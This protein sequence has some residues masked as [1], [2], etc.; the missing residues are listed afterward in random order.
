MPD[1]PRRAFIAKLK[2]RI[3]ELEAIGPGGV[4]RELRTELDLRSA[5]LR[6]LESGP[7][8]GG[9]AMTNENLQKESGVARATMYRS[10]AMED[11]RVACTLAAPR[12][13]AGLRAEVKELRSALS[14]MR[15]AHAAERRKLIAAQN[16]LVQRVQALTIALVAARGGSKVVDIS[17]LR[18]SR[19]R[20]GAL[21]DVAP[22]PPLR[23]G[24]DQPK[25]S[26]DA[27]SAASPK[28]VGG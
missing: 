18:A 12:S 21:P 13:E 24:R 11:W 7:L 3:A 26:D 2:S 22:Q 8:R 5:M 6:L 15:D 9:N 19:R 10:S 28:G 1:D 4:T 25:R 16:V 14:R 20:V 23:A 17:T 27:Q